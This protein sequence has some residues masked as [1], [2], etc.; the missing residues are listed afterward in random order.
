MNTQKFKLTNPETYPDFR[1]V[2]KFD[3]KQL[4]AEEGAEGEAVKS[5]RTENVDSR[6]GRIALLFR[7]GVID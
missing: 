2:L 7:I 5:P 3:L 1:N 6:R 4:S